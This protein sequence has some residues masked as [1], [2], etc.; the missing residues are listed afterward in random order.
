MFDQADQT[1]N[2]IDEDQN[3]E[4]AKL[5]LKEINKQSSDFKDE[6][7]CYNCGEKKHIASKCLKFKQENFQINTIENFRQ[8]IQIVVEKASSIRFIIKIFDESTVRL[9]T[10]VW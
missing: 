7:V 1:D 5:F 10:D 2:S 8:S 6:R 4:I 3:N 9:C